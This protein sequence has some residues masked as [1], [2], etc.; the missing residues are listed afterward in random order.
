MPNQYPAGIEYVVVNGVVV[1]TPK[2][3]TGARPGD[4]LLHNGAV[5]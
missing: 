2:G 5:R 4:R 3:L 1:L